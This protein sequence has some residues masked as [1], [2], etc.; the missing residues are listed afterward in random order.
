MGDLAEN[1]VER[2]FVGP[3]SEPICK[4]EAVD[5]LGPIVRGGRAEHL[6]G[7]ML[8]AVG[9]DESVE[10]GVDSGCCAF[11]GFDEGS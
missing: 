6:V 1:L 11:G 5:A 2:R 7:C 8:Q 10:R 4:I 3:I 9:I